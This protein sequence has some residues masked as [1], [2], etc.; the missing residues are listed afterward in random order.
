MLYLR[1]KNDL[2]VEAC[3]FLQLNLFSPWKC[4]CLWPHN[5]SATVNGLNKYSFLT[6]LSTSPQVRVAV[7]ISTFSSPCKPDHLT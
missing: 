6:L 1:N 2:H 7:I 5:I 4:L 3:S